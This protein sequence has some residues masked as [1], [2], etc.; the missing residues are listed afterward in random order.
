M[1]IEVGREK[2]VGSPPDTIHIAAPRGARTVE[3]VLG[4]KDRWEVPRWVFIDRNVPVPDDRGVPGVLGPGAIVL[5]G[6]AV[7]YAPPK[8]GLLSD[9][10]YVLPGAIRARAQDLRAIAPNLTP[11]MSVYLY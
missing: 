10:A 9:S 1:P 4:A 11:G 6:G 2:R 8:E 5:S 7:I 3:R